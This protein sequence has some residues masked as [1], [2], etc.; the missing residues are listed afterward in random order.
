MSFI[1]KLHIDT[2]KK[3]INNCY[4]ALMFN[5]ENIIEED[6][7]VKLDKLFEISE[8]FGHMVRVDTWD[9]IK[10]TEIKNMKNMNEN[11]QDDED[12][13][14]PPGRRFHI[15]EHGNVV[16]HNKYSGAPLLPYRILGMSA[17]DFTKQYT[18]IP[19]TKRFSFFNDIL[20]DEEREKIIEV[21]NILIDY[22]HIAPDNDYPE[23]LINILNQYIKKTLQ[24]RDSHLQYK[25]LRMIADKID[26]K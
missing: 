17:T 6:N 26:K 21:I 12:E 1:S 14:L 19:K 22:E 5:M 20:R 8:N 2:V 13:N 23:K 10:K 25:Y 11:K 24:N 9:E 18:Y 15:D 4:M 7:N 3:I 16:Y